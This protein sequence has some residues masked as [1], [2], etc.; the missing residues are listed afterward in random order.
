MS[1][2]AAVGGGILLIVWPRDILFI[3]E[4]CER[5]R[6]WYRP[7]CAW[8]DVTYVNDALE[9]TVSRNP[10]ASF[11]WAYTAATRCTKNV[12]NK[13]ATREQYGRA[14]YMKQLGLLQHVREV[15]GCFQNLGV[16]SVSLNGSRAS[17]QFAPNFSLDPHL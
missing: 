3:A 11:W 4:R 2:W 14:F 8:R 10:A 9:C 16:A 5:G 17:R 13:T 15:S 6:S 1:R 7:T 12:R